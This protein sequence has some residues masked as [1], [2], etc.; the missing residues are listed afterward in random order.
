MYTYWINMT[1]Y[2]VI[3]IE[4]NNKTPVLQ[5]CFVT[6]TFVLS[7]LV[8]TPDPGPP[9]SSPAISLLAS[10]LKSTQNLLTALQKSLPPN[11][12]LPA[13]IKTLAQR[14]LANP[15]T[16]TQLQGNGCGM[17]CTDV[18]MTTLLLSERLC[19]CSN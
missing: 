10:N 19:I 12:N 8:V 5:I 2:G 15:L 13:N 6:L 7:P 17:L 9:L 4:S 1:L 18:S 14:V 3:E 11:A 16:R